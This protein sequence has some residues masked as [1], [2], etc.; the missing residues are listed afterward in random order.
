MKL[1]EMSKEELLEYISSLNEE[2]TGKLGLLWDREKVPEKIVS[3]CNKY[4]PILEEVKSKTIDNGG[5]ENLLIEGD[6]FHSLSVLNYT[7]KEAIDVIYIDPPYNTGNRDFM[8]N[9]KFVDIEDGYKHSKWLNFMEKRLK[10]AKNLLKDE[11]IIFISIDDNELSQLK[12]L[13][14][15]IFGVRCFIGNF[16]RKSSYGEK[17]SKPKINKHHDY[18]LCYCKKYDS[19]I[20]TDVL[21]G[22]EKEFKE[23]DNPDNDPR[24]E[25]KKDSYLIKIDSGRYGYARYPITNKYL[26]ITHYPP[27]YYDEE[28]RKQWHYT[29]EKF[30]EMERNGQVVYYKTKEEMGNSGY[31]FYIK[32]YRDSISDL[33]SNVSTTFFDKNEYV[34][35]NGSKDLTNV[36]G[37]SKSIMGLYPKPVNFIKKLIQFSTCYNKDA[38]ILDFFAG[39]GTTAQAVLELNKEDGGHRKFIICTNNESDICDSITYPRCKTILTGKRQDG[40]E[41]SNSVKSNIR[42]FKTKFVNNTGTRDQLYYDLTEK[43]IPML[44]VKESTHILVEKNDEYMIFTNKDKSKYACIYFDMFGLKYSQF[45]SK[46]EQIEEYKSIYIFTLDNQ[47]S[48]DELIDVKNYDIEPIP[49]KILELYKKIVETE[50]EE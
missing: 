42:Y 20:D 22:E 31:S 49:Y 32:K 29:E 3:D 1:E 9:D 18:C 5:E 26:N 50:M 45:I 34:N 13:C 10:L 15:R 30:K 37:K 43:C 19:V 27:V 8:Y 28:N 16:I 40:S 11:G 7:H 48:K 21:G 17:T 12:L 38:T 33:R 24:G 44:C 23:Y 14:D 6:N 39:S 2:Q 47:V 41:Y 25:W 36:I 46:I 4:I 35:G